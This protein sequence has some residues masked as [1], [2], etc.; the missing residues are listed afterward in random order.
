MTEEIQNPL[1]IALVTANNENGNET[2][3]VTIVVKMYT[4]EY[5]N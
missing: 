4:M 2:M 3:Q 5:V 1:L